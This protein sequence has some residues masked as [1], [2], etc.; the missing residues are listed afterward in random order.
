MYYYTEDDD[1]IFQAQLES[2]KVT[3]EKP[4]VIYALQY[5]IKAAKGD[6]IKT[7]VNRLIDTAVCKDH[8]D[9]TERLYVSM[10]NIRKVAKEMVGDNN[11]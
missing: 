3:S 6:A 11:G 2:A 1:K 7:F 5:A 4:H 10:E 8:G 9:G